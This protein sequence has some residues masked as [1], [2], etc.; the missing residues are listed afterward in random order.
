MN[1]AFLCFCKISTAE[2]AEGRNHDVY[3]SVSSRAPRIFKGFFWNGLRWMRGCSMA[4]EIFGV[5]AETW[6]KAK[7]E[8]TCAIV[9]A[10]RRGDLIFYSKYLTSHR[11]PSHPS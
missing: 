7:L 9:R 1:G 8:A 2:H 6:E 5:K 3:L 10:G 4:G 11:T